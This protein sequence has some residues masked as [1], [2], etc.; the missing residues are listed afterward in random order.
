MVAQTRRMLGPSVSGSHP[1]AGFNLTNR[2]DDPI[3]HLELH[4]GTLALLVL[5][6]RT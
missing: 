6:L 2:S 5:L 1:K 4:R 3:V